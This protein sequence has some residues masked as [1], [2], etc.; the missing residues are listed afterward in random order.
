L[1]SL[2]ITI[3][4][5]LTP[6][7]PLLLSY[8]TSW[9]IA[10][11]S[12]KNWRLFLFGIGPTNFLEAF[13]QFRP[14]SYN[15][16]NLWAIRF[17]SSSN[18]YF[19]LLTTVG[20]LGIASFLWLIGKTIKTQIKFNQEGSLTVFVPLLTILIIFLFLSP[21]FLLLFCFYLFLALLAL[22]LPYSGEYSETSKIASWAIF[23]PTLLFVLC[24]LFFTGRTYAA[25]VFFRRSLNALAQNDGTGAYS[26]QVKAITLNPFHDLYRLAYSQTNLALAYSLASRSGLSDQDR[27]N[28][29]ALVQQAIREAKA[30]V[31]LNKNK[32]V[33]WEN[34]ANI[35]RQLINFAQGSDQWAITA[36]SQAIKL[37]PTNPQL[38]LNLGGIY[39]ALKNYDEAIRFFQQAV[40]IKPNFANGYY[41]LSA[42]YREKS[43]FQKAHEAMLATLNLVPTTSEDYNKA[44]Q[45]LDELAK[46]VTA[47]EA[48]QAKPEKIPEPKPTQQPLIEPEPYPSPVITPPIELPEEQAAPDVSPAPEATP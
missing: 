5:L 48:A 34:L 2:V 24:C 32:V 41:N 27:Q 31:S 37:D 14:V 44:R 23:I 43:N 46:K 25:E 26:N 11:E 18:Y 6:N 7:K 3:W 22:N 36:L 17:S 30:A 45:E 13:S 33:N 29:T 19:H 12:F 38:K 21:N 28:I 10:V 4:Q 15:L 20:A 8:S 9:A 16:S 35:Y 42:A 1:G 40:E 39:Y 47:S